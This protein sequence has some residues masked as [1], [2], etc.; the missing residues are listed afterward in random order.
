[1]LKRLLLCL[2]GLWL[3]IP[4]DAQEPPCPC[5]VRQP[6]AIVRENAFNLILRATPDESAPTVTVVTPGTSLYTLTRTGDSLWIRVETLSGEQGWILAQ[7]LDITGDVEQIPT[8]SVWRVPYDADSFITGIT[9]HARQIFRQ[10]QARGN[11]AG[12]FSKVGDSITVATH[13]LQPVGQ[14]IYNLAAYSYM[15]PTIQAF[16]GTLA[17]SDNAFRNQSLAAMIG[18]TTADVL[19]PGNGDSRLCVAW[20][21]PLNCEY[22][23][24]RPAIAFIMF[25][26]NDVEFMSPEVFHVRLSEVVRRTLA[27]D[28]IPVLSTIP[29]RPGFERAVTAF[30]AQIKAL[31]VEYSIP[32]IDY[33][34]AMADLPDFGLDVDDVHPGIPPLGYD[35]A[36]DFK[37]S[38]LPYGYVIRN[39]LTLQALHRLHTEVILPELESNQA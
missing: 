32:L 33:G 2:C 28:I 30:N 14:G 37:R 27:Y 13:F 22:R 9:P 18:W 3:I 39:L 1:M 15:E 12:V 25:G 36:A 5:D 11:R 10:G 29:P 19:R 26:T 31:S 21:S 38:N 23:L 34:R 24:V 6:D 4:S 35:G 17:R 20:E 16:S 8:D 7:F